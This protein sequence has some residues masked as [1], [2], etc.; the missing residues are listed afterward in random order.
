M[1][2][3]I[4]VLGCLISLVVPCLAVMLL[5]GRASYS[6][7]PPI[8]VRNNSDHGV[9]LDL[10]EGEQHFLG[11]PIPAH[12]EAKEFEVSNPFRPGDTVRFRAVGSGALLETRRLSSADLERAY[13]SDRIVFVFPKSR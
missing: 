4:K 2:P 12:T 7:H 5:Y 13:A 8:Y 9:V 11:K 6:P 3:I 10:A 1:K